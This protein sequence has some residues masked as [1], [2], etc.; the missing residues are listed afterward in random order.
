[1]I[2]NDQCRSVEGHLRNMLNVQVVGTSVTRA[3]GKYGALENCNL[4]L[5]MK[6]NQKS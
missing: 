5:C 3:A 1:M 2:T 6:T 4:L